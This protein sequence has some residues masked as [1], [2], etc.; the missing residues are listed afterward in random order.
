MFAELTC[1]SCGRHLGEVELDA[2]G[3]PRR[4]RPA[5]EGATTATIAWR[6]VAGGRSRPYCGRCGGRA[7]I[8]PAVGPPVRR[9]RPEPVEAGAGVPREA[10]RRSA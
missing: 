1:L 8:E 7:V 6:P 10:G 4:L 5:G 3:V 2:A 9:A